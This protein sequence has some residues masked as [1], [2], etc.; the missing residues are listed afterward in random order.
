MQAQ[1]QQE[2]R[3]DIHPSSSSSSCRKILVVEDDP[4]LANFLKRGLHGQQYTV[5]IQ[6]DGA[7]ALQTLSSASWDLLLLDLTLPDLDGLA[8]LDRLRPTMPNLP[9]LVLTG[10]T[11]LEDRVTALDHGADDCL[12]KPFSFSELSARIRALLRRNS[13]GRG[14][15][16]QVSDLT[17]DREHFRVER[18]GRRID[19]TEKEFALLEYLMINARR[20]VTRSMIMENVWKSDYNANSNLVDVYIKYVRDKVDGVGASP[21]LLRTMRGVGYVIADN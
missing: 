7:T 3:G 20:T 12:L 2:I 9:I 15:V 19:L 5:D 10:R 13:N 16:L 18:G 4:A 11:A 21:K 8:L 6:H 14:K 17:M 1:A